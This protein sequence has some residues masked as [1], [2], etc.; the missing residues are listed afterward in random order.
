VTSDPPYSSLFL[1]FPFFIPARRP[2]PL[3]VR[4]VW[5]HQSS[6]ILRIRSEV[7]ISSERETRIRHPIANISDKPLEI[8]HP[9]GDNHPDALSSSPT[10][11]GFRRHAEPRGR[12]KRADH[13]VQYPS[14]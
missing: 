13:A 3:R 1:S 2:R 5:A 10:P 14:C 9:G 12:R 6:A 11:T 8:E 4:V 7:T